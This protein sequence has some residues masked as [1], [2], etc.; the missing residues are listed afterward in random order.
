MSRDIKFK[1]WDA[2]RGEMFTSSKWVE[3]LVNKDGAIRAQNYNRKGNVQQLPVMQ[4]TGLKD[5]DGIEIYE[6]DIIQTKADGKVAIEWSKRAA[7]FGI[8]V[9][10]DYTYSREKKPKLRAIPHSCTVIGNIYQN[11]KLLKGKRNVEM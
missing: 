11:P 8:H 6:G 2:E 9:L 3:F 5:K 10:R 7:K 4:Y 1:A